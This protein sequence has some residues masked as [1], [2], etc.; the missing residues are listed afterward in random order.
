MASLVEW[1]SL[2][3]KYGLLAVLYFFFA[4]FLIYPLF[5]I[6]QGAF[7]VQ[8]VKDGEIVWRFSLE[9]FELIFSNAFYRDCFINSTAIA[10]WTTFFCLLISLPLANLFLRWDFPLK[11]FWSSAILLPLI[12]PPFVGAIG[13]KQMFARFGSLNLLLADLGWVDLKNPPDWLGEGGFVGIVI[14]E[15]LHL[16]PI[17]FLSVQAAMANVDPSLR[18]AARNLG[19]KSFRIFRT[20]TVPLATPGIFSGC[21]IV[22]VFAFTDLGVPLMFNFQTTVPTQIFNLVTQSDNPVG[23]ALVLVALVVVTLFFILGKRFGEGNYA[24]MGR[25]ASYEDVRRFPFVVSWIVSAVVGIVIFVSILPH[26]G[27]IINSFA[28]RWFMSVFPQEWTGE[29]YGEIFSIPLTSIS[30]KNSLQYAVLSSLLDLVLGVT[31]AYLLVRQTFK[32]KLILD[33]LAMLPLA[34]PGLVTAF[35]YYVAFTRPPFDALAWIDP[36]QNPTLL[37]V[38]AYAI[39]RLPY[40]VRAAV[41]GLQQTSVTLEEAS[42][43]LGAKPLQ[44]LWKVTLPLIYANLIAGTI[45]TFSFAMLDVSKGMILAQETP[46]YPITKAI[47]ALLARIIPNASAIACAMGVLAMLLLAACLFIA[48]KLLGQKMGQLFKA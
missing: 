23:Y 5:T 42:A 41:A 29:N 17:M 6:L 26:L 11:L 20:V 7:W 31:I 44:T 9:Y 27:V 47:Y 48:S 22:F 39:H 13:L 40:I 25:S 32:G 45:M 46:F 4:A 36:R 35:A 10:A 38:V 1:R 28:A 21:A 43:N 24:M 30:I 34:L 3:K 14:L 12:L 8:S 33:V 19:A 37:L 2:V 18:D 15:V 16:Y